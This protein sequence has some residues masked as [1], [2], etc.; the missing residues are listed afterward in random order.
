VKEPASQP[1]DVL[2]VGGGPVGVMTGLLL[3]QRGFSVRVLERATEIYDLPRAIVMDDEIQRV[4]QN[5]GLQD[6]LRAI[7]TPLAGAEFVSTSG[8][9]I[10]GAE[11]PLDANWPLGHHPNITYYQPQLEAFIRDSAEQA[12]VEL[13]LGVEVGAVSQ[14]EDHVTVEAMGPDGSTQTH[15]ASWLVA[16][17]GASSPIRKQLG[18]VFINQGYDQ[19]WLVLDVRLQ[20]PVPTLPE[21]VQQICDPDRPTTF[22]VGHADY[23]RWEFQLQP[24][25]TRE[26]MVEPDR[27]WELLRPW[28]TP[29]D[30]ELIRAVVYRFHATVAG[31]MRDRRIFIAGDAAHQMPPFLGQG[32][33]SG[34]RDSA[35]LAW[36]LRLVELG[37]A[38]DTL[39]DT[40]GEERMPHA[41]GVVAHAV[42]TGRLIDELSGRAIQETGLDAAYGGGRPFPHLTTGL[43]HG[44]H[45]AVGR[46]VH[47]PLIDGTRLDELCGSGFAIIV[48][49]PRTAEVVAEDWTDLGEVVVVP[50]GT[51]PAMLP[52]G[53]AVIVRPDRYV[54]AV[55]ENADELQRASSDLL[56]RIRP[57]SETWDWDPAHLE[58]LRSHTWAVLAT[59]RSDGSPQQSMI[60]YAVDDE[61]RLLISAKSYTAKWNNAARLPK[62][63]V[64]V[65]DGRAHLVV[66]GVAETIDADP[67]RAELTAQVFGALSGNPPPDPVTLASMLD[68]QQ[69]TVLRI[70]P[71]K[72]LFQA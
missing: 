15:T 60:G 45:P 27:V 6:G 8:E 43:L 59:G 33:C 9:R 66:Y 49:D 20:R 69:R 3:A 39:L 12:G 53:G 11:L 70:T 5:A 7:T 22:V 36:K 57:I 61:G 34:V 71:T 54:A 35:N 64:T 13:C 38:G 48:D 26:E 63:S 14:T 23:R 47:Q 42:D 50:P 67:L 1:L 68:E 29:D 2:V 40:Y 16:A 18:I 31:K 30:A 21:F 44:D 24:G 65:P 41:A 17:D 72:T 4:F 58:F 32:L 51:I 37:L 56:S 19:D 55:A 10:V 28:L 25:E 52:P 62:V 46:Q